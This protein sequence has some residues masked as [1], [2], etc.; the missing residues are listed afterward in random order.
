MSVPSQIFV[1][2]T[3]RK[4]LN[5]CCLWLL[6]VQTIYAQHPQ[7][8][9]I[10][11]GMKKEIIFTDQAPAPIGPYSQAVAVGNLI[12]VSGQIAIDPAG[13]A[14]VNSSIVRETH[15]VMQNIKSILEKAGLDMSH[16]VKATI[17]LT[18]M[19]DF[20]EVNSVYSSYFQG[21]YPARETVEV[22]GLPKNAHVE[23]SVIAYR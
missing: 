14:M 17:F 11:Q 19:E 3:E 5:C 10:K 4:L 22:A 1:F 6:F 7:K 12:F 13:G 9:E 18:N 8:Q 15:Q 20:A 23:I 16:I 21:Q 2:T